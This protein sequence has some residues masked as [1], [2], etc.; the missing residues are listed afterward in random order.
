MKENIFKIT[1]IREIDKK[2]IA[3]FLSENWASSV[4]VSKGKIHETT[5]LPG[6]ICKEKNKIIG[7][8][9]YNIENED[10]EIV[11]L[12]SNFENKGWDQL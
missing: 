2:L 4:S 7:L 5:Q 8:V 9:T 11:T 1:E 12:D 6:F 10:C 3:R